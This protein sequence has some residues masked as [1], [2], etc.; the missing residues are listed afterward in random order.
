MDKA[1]LLRQLKH[2]PLRVIDFKDGAKVLQGGALLKCAHLL[3]GA[4]LRGEIYLHH[5]RIDKVPCYP[6]YSLNKEKPDKSFR[7]VPIPKSLL[8]IG[9]WHG[10]SF[11]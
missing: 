8:A 2:G 9:G 4:L 3:A 10:C 1:M 6:V 7:W 5:K 11:E